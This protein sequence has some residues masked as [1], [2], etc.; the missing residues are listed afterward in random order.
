[1]AVK[2]TNIGLVNHCK[3]LLETKTAYMWG[4]LL[5]NITDSYI[6]MLAKMYPSQYPVARQKKLRALP[7][8]YVGVDCVG[9]IKSYYFSGD[10]EGGTMGSKYYKGTQDVNAHGM[11]N[12]AKVKGRIGT[13]PEVPGLVVYCKSRPHVGV[14]IGNGYV[15]ES[16]LSSKGDGVIMTKLDNWI[17]EYWLECPFISYENED[18]KMVT[19]TAT[20]K[21]HYSKVAELAGK[22]SALGFAVKTE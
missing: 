13:M 7:D 19:I 1:M 11:Y 5:R 18:D 2:Y 6:T 4:G 9:L 8:S 14:Y 16:T 10:S 17:W 22:V 15:I 3:K 21:V 20:K 12:K